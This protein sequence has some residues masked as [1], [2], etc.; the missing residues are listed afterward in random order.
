MGVPKEQ[1]DSL[2]KMHLKQQK[3]LE[4]AHAELR[5][6]KVLMETKQKELEQLLAQLSEKTKYLEKKEEEVV[7]LRTQLKAA[8]DSKLR[9][10]GETLRRVDDGR[11]KQLED[12]L[13]E[14]QEQNDSLITQRTSLQ[15]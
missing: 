14:M 11:L 2:V 4:V 8:Q 13:R 6:R 7:S 3:E 10:E 12:Q 9:L 15:K 1:H 5:D